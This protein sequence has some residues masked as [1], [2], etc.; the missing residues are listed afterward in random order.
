MN[1]GPKGTGAIDLKDLSILDS[2][3]QWMSKNSESIYGTSPSPL[4]MQ[5]WG[6]STMKNNRLYLHVFKW[7][8]NNKLIVGGLKSKVTNAWFLE[9]AGKKNLHVTRLNPTDIC[10]RL[11]NKMPDRVNTVIVLDIE[12]KIETE[13]IRIA[14]P[15]MNLRLLAFDAELHGKDL[16]F[17]DGKFKRYYVDNWVNKEQWME[18]KFRVLKSASYKIMLNYTGSE[19]SGGSFI[20]LTDNI[21]LKGKIPDIQRKGEVNSIFSGTIYLKKGIHHLQ[22]KPESITKS[23]LMKILEV[24]LITAK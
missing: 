13:P 19:E 4:P 1:I 22:I 9:D 12:D 2:L 17:G 8:A 15:G 16:R 10:I 6:V 3:G 23:E 5:S 14:T 7:P 24:S 18:W 20:I 21:Q 11:T